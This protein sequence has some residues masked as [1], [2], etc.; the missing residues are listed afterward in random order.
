M[1]ESLDE[2]R[3]LGNDAAHLEAKVYDEIGSE[4]VALGIDF[5]KEILESLYQHEGLLNRMKSLKKPA[6][7]KTAKKAAKKTPTR[8]IT[9]EKM[10][11]KLP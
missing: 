11:G 7:K 9:A 4:E 5:T 2:L 8:D 1:I 6:K 3:Y 10:K